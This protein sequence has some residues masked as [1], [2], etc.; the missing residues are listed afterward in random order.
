M[1]SDIVVLA[2]VLVIGGY[3][4][5]S[6]RSALWTRARMGRYVHLEFA[7]SRARGSKETVRAKVLRK[8]LMAAAV[9]LIV[10]L[11]M[12]VSRIMQS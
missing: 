5:F 3:A 11:F 8:W 9:A 2:C 4:I 7:P 1:A 6:F 12:L 10:L